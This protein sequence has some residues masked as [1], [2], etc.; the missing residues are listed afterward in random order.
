MVAA[1]NQLAEDSVRVLKEKVLAVADVVLL[2][3]A[4]IAAVFGRG[5][6]M[7][8]RRLTGLATD[9]AR[10]QFADTE[11]SGKDEVGVLARAFNRMSSAL[12]ERDEEVLRMRQVLSE[13]ESRSWQ[14]QMSQWL[15]AD[16]SLA[17]DGMREIIGGAEAGNSGVGDKR[18]LGAL[19]E[20]AQRALKSAFSRAAS[21][22]RRVRDAV[23][24]ARDSLQGAQVQLRFEAPNAV[25]FPRLPAQE[26]ELREIVLTLVRFGARAAPAD[27]G[28]IRVTAYTGDGSLC[29]AVSYDLGAKS[30]DAARRAIR[31][32]ESL[33][34][35][36]RASATL[37]RE[38]SG[39]AAVLEFPLADS[40]PSMEP[41]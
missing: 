6:T 19:V 21:G 20:Q 12:R 29:L 28:A 26:S 18:R 16:L 22:A 33:L 14:K 2:L 39:V 4:F 23:D 9:V 3:A 10:G 1:P 8:L 40:N 30:R 34:L 17:L 41:S 38:G 24:L 7:R 35:S 15:E 11:V 36:H 25:L 5:M 31:A 13:E 27:G 37:V 32:V